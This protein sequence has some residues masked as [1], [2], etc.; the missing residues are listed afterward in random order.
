MIINRVRLPSELLWKRNWEL[1]ERRLQHREEA[2]KFYLDL[3]AQGTKVRLG[4]KRAVMRAGLDDCSPSCS[5]SMDRGR[6][7]D[8]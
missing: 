6:R 4:W 7:R 8:Q 2:E 3:A 5:L 1:Q